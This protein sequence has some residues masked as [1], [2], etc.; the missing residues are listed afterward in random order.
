MSSVW[1]TVATGPGD[2]QEDWPTGVLP[3]IIGALGAAIGLH[4][5]AFL[6]ATFSVPASVLGIVL[7]LHSRNTEAIAVGALG[8]AIAIVAL[9]NSD[10]FWFAFGVIGGALMT[11]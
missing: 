8:I 7:G 6:F 4:A 2:S 3:A 1:M 5:L 10:A 11:G 9:L